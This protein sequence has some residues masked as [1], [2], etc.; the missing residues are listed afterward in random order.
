MIKSGVLKY[1]LP[2]QGVKL[3]NSGRVENKISKSVESV[4]GGVLAKLGS[5]EPQDPIGS[6]KKWNK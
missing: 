4:F 3:R 6:N 1:P 2:R 5:L